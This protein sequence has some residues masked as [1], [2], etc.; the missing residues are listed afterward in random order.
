M[1]QSSDVDLSPLN[2]HCKRETFPSEAPFHLARRVPGNT[3]KTVTDMWNGYHSVPLRECDRH[4]T[5]FITPFGRWRYLRAPQGFLSSGDGY[6][7]RFDAI[8]SNFQRKER[9]VDD[10]IH[11]DEDLETHWW[12]T[13][14]LLHTAG[15]AGGVMNPE[16]LQFAVRIADFAGF[17][18]T[19]DSIE[20]LPKYLDAIRSFPTPKST[21][22]IRSWFGLVNQVSN[23]AQLRDFMEIFR[24]FFTLLVLEYSP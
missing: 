15:A 10:T 17:H 20:P 16:K 5:T 1:T 13:I 3:W 19:E 8:L 23:Y 6:N 12:R 7:R 4:L 21:K 14:D 24:P 2:K 9:C 11:F 22:D 18:I